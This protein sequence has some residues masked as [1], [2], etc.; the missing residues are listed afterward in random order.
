[1]AFSYQKRLDAL[2]GLTEADRITV[3]RIKQ[4][5]AAIH[6][7]YALAHANLDLGRI[8]DAQALAAGVRPDVTELTR[9]VRDL[10]GRQSDKA[11]VVGQRLASLAR[12]REIV[13]WLVLVATALVGALVGVFTLRWVEGPLVRLVT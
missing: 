3:N 8:R 2:P 7:D 1:S 4:L 10:S 5:Q 13:L 12:Q 11:A 9:L 6:V